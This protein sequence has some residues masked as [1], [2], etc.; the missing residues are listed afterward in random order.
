MNSA[1]FCCSAHINASAPDTST[2]YFA[3]ALICRKQE[4]L[5]V[6]RICCSM[7]NIVSGNMRRFG[8]KFA[9]FAALGLLHS[10]LAAA[11]A[12]STSTILATTATA[13]L[14]SCLPFDCTLSSRIR[15]FS[16]LRPRS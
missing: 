15:G 4:E 16:P 12:R 14:S 10:V 5:N 11:P 13:V 8:S 9:L 7:R 6:R 3:P 1:G 2:A